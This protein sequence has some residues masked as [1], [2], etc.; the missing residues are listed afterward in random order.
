MVKATIQS[1]KPYCKN[2]NDFYNAILPTGLTPK[3]TLDSVIYKQDA[4]VRG[5]YYCY[6]SNRV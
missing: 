1:L 4:P 3:E 6:F 2:K 5:T